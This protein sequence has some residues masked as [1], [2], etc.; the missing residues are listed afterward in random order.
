VD[1]HITVDIAAPPDTVW[2]VIA[3]VERWPEWTPSVRGIRLVDKG[4]FAIGTR[5]WVRQP[6][7]PPALWKVTALEPGKSFTWRTGAPGMRVDARHAVAAAAGGSR[8]QLELHYAGPIG[9][10]LARLT[11]EI[12]DRYLAYEAAG[13]KAR[14]ESLTRS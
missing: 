12:T 13:L 7:F 11:R 10:L 1:F 6:R 4:A 14:S 2:G 9:N 8:A 3:D 5:A